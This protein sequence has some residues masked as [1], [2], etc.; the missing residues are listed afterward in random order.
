L[1]ADRIH[2]LCVLGQLTN[3][4]FSVLSVSSTEACFAVQSGRQHG[5]LVSAEIPI[6]V[7][8]ADV[9][10]GSAPQSRIPVRNGAE[11]GRDALELL[12]NGPLSV[13]VSDHSSITRL[14]NRPTIG[15]TAVG[16]RL[17]VLWE[18][19]VATGRIDLM[20]FVAVS[21]TNAAK[22][23]NFYPKKVSKTLNF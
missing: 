3:S 19:A 21:S 4:P 9:I 1:E 20:R 5:T 13:C 18:K 22:L 11:N 7:L 8:A 15:T 2:R 10:S 17:A 6:S 16:E 23:F 14:P 12:A